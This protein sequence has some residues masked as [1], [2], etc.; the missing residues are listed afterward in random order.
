MIT[1]QMGERT[2][3]KHIYRVVFWNN[4]GEIKVTAPTTYEDAY[5]TAESYK[6][7]IY[8]MESSQP[9]EDKI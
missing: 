6:G 2:F 8:K 7:V 4:S 3:N 1:K 9:I 5:K